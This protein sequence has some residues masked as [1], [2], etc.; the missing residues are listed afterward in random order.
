MDHSFAPEVRSS[1]APWA[2]YALGIGGRLASVA[3]TGRFGYSADLSSGLP[4]W[5]SQFL[6]MLS[7]CAP[8]AVSAA[9]LQAF[10]EGIRPARV[11]LAVL[12]A[13]EFVFGAVGGGKQTFVITV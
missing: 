2:L 12:A 1:L 9:A 7:L 11:T 10:R 3:A 5:Y 13:S 8:L 6:A 4:S